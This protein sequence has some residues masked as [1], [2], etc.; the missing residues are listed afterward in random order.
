MSLPD[1]EGVVRR[2][3]VSSSWKNIQ[4][5][6]FK[7]ID[8]CNRWY[9]DM[10]AIQFVS[11]EC[12][13]FVVPLLRYVLIEPAMNGPNTMIIY[14]FDSRY[15]PFLQ[16]LNKYMSGSTAINP[17]NHYSLTGLNNFTNSTV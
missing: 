13:C 8:K 1:S 17:W 16:E 9:R 10:G 2:P 7:A 11:G 4:Q 12:A 15:S 3:I 6:T 5:A 14:I